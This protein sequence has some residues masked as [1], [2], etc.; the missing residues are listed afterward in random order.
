[1]YD[2]LISVAIAKVAISREAIAVSRGVGV[3]VVS[4]VSHI[5]GLLPHIPYL[6][7]ISIMFVHLIPCLEANAHKLAY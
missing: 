1:M 6:P 5:N 4:I 7:H 3:G 2:G